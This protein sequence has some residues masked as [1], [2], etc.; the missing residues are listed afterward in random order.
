MLSRRFVMLFIVLIIGGII[1]GYHHHTTFAQGNNCLATPFSNGCYS[2]IPLVEYQQLLD[3]MM[4][5]PEPR[6]EQLPPNERELKRFNF[7]RLINPEGTIIYDA[8]NGN[9]ISSIA[10]GF[11]YVSISN[12]Q[13]GWLEINPGQWVRESDTA[14]VTP[15]SFSGVFV[16]P[17]APYTMAWMLYPVRP[18]SYPGGPENTDLARIPRYTRLNIYH[19]V[20]VDGWRWYLVGPEQWVKQVNVGKVLYIDRPEGVKGRWFAVDLYEQVL[21]AYENDTPVFATLVSTGL[22]EW[23]TNEGTFTTWARVA[24]A[25][26]SGAEGQ[27]DFYSLENVPWTLYFDN[28]ISLHGTYW[29]D[30]FGYRHSHGCV[31]LTLTDS[32]WIFHWSQEAGYD[33]PQVHV[34]AS[35]EYR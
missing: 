1:L 31:N 35:G 28:D 29:H 13:G 19:S 21:V 11:N 23:E 2:G 9:P 24:N 32:Y 16:D 20:E 18:S 34:W 33:K 5:Y 22:P 10:A 7:R 26:M 8:P 6:V 25:P 14:P 27:E 12:S 3:E 17:N 15:S 30:G 4:L